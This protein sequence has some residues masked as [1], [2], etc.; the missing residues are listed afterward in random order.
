M[1]KKVASSRRRLRTTRSVVTRA[2][3]LVGAVGPLLELYAALDDVFTED[4][5]LTP[6]FRKVSLGRCYE[7]WKKCRKAFD[8]DFVAAEH[9][10]PRTRRGLSARVRERD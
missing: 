1:P 6:E 5:A 4:N 8:P 7:A 2:R 9:R 10:R 3:E